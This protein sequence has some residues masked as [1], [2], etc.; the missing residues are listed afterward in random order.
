MPFGNYNSLGVAGGQNIPH[1]PP[2]P[3]AGQQLSQQ[4]EA[5]TRNDR[6]ARID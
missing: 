5:N 4:M 6:R 1:I 3:T 2:F